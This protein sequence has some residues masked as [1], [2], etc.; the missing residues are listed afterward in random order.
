M[1]LDRLGGISYHNLRICA[2]IGKYIRR[3][4]QTEYQFPILPQLFKTTC[5]KL[6]QFTIVAD[7]YCDHTCILT[8]KGITIFFE[9]E[10]G[11]GAV[12]Q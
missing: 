6:Q 4:V 9:S 5:R 2:K 7:P 1:S 10:F 8:T 12:S 3:P 11:Q